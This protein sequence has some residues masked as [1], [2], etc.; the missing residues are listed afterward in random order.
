M[1]PLRIFQFVS[2]VLVFL[3]LLTQIVFPYL[4]KRKLFPLF[5]KKGRELEE[6]LSEVRQQEAENEIKEEIQDTKRRMKFTSYQRQ[7]KRKRKWDITQ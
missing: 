1:I 4:A 3:F 7:R 5:R 2:L 6:T